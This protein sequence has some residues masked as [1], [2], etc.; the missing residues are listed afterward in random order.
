MK[1]PRY[2]ILLIIYSVLLFAELQLPDKHPLDETE[3]KTFILDNGLKVIL[4]SNPK[5]NISAASMNVKVGSLS[6]PED[7][8][9]L[10]HFLEHMLFLGT[11]KYPDVEDYKMYLSNNGGYSNAYTAEDHTNYLFE[12][13]HE[14]Y[15]G[16][17]DRF[18][19][20]FIAPAFNPDF[21]KREVNA[22]N[23]EFQKNL[24]HDYW[25]MRQIKRTIYD[26]GHPSNHFEIGSLETLEKVDRQVL[27]DFHKKYYSANQMALALLSKFPITSMEEWAKTY[28]GAIEN[29]QAKDIKYSPVYLSEKEAIRLIQIKPIKDKK[30]LELE[31]PL[32]FNLN[33][34]Y[35]SKPMGILGTLIGYEGEGSL[36]SFL[37]EKGLATGLMAG[38]SPNTPDYGSAG[39][40]I[41]LTEKGVRDYLQVL[42]YFFSYIDMLK[43]EGYKE[44]LFYEQ[45]TIARLEEVFSDKGE[46]TW[47]AV[48]F[49]NN[50]AFYPVEIA[51]RVE[52][53][54]GNPDPDAYLKTLSFIHPDNMLCVLSDSE[55]ETP[56]EEFWYKSKYNYKEIKG[57]EYKVLKNPKFYSSLHLP[58]A[59]PFLPENANLL[60]EPI[61]KV[62]N[63]IL[64]EQSKG[65]KLYYKQDAHFQRPKASYSYKIYFPEKYSDLNS[66]VL[67]ELYIAAVNESMNE[68]SYPAKLAGMNYSVSNDAEG[69]SIIVSGYSDSIDDLLVEVIDN[70]NSIDIPDEQFKAMKNQMIRDWKNIDLGDAHR[71]ASEN[72]RKI[73]RKYYYT[74]VELADAAKKLTLRDVKNFSLLLMKK[75]FVEAMVFGNVTESQAKENTELLIKKLKIKAVK[76]NKVIKQGRIIFSSGEEI[77]SVINSQVNNSCLWRFQYFGSNSIEED[78]QAQVIGNYVGS[79]FYLEMRTNQ[80]LGYIV[81]GGA[82]SFDNSSY[83]YFV[84]QSGNYSPASLSDKVETFTATLPDSLYNLPEEEFQIIKNGVIE[85]IKEKPTSI[86]EQAE[87]YNSLAFDYNA[88]FNRKEELIHAVNNLSK[89]QAIKVLKRVLNSN[90]MEKSSILLFAK[91]HEID[92]NIQSSFD[93]INQWKNT[94]EYE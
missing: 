19:Q 64:L 6:D 49:A 52:Y 62:E 40:R 50:L 18:S 1:F 30:E 7:A 13:I 21:T 10:A 90:T 81:W 36:L 46:G 55:Q 11:E 39:I 73:V 32:P 44:Y 91:E 89:E 45:Q 87:Q 74:N 58:D 61:S 93:D 5:Y 51:H 2:I 92:A 80:Q 53:H 59:N 4:V 42:G 25:R 66:Q 35:D 26:K 23:S 86:A 9:G 16:A 27:L 88:N 63:P 71:I 15:E 65:L 78:A 54:Y 79:P 72:M 33:Q 22:V 38:G 56:F 57:D 67:M 84:I 3:T 29:N 83:F 8:Q 12:V 77:I 34:F 48:S 82:E 75:G 31:F 69:I 47:K 41:Q 70:M 85:K 43:T 24:E 28:F 14:A 76:K 17:L 60:P 20:F 94:R 68:A 37:K